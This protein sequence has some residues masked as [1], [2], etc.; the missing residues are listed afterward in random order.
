MTASRV[1]T[2]NA[3][4]WSKFSKRSWTYSGS[5]L[6]LAD[7]PAGHDG[8]RAVLTERAGQAQHD[9]VGRARHGSTAA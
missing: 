9:A 2:A 3:D 6:G 7:E 1:A 8:D 4:V 5:G